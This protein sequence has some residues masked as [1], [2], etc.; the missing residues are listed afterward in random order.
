[1]GNVLLQVVQGNISI[2][3]VTLCCFS[4]AL[5]E[6]SSEQTLQDNFFIFPLDVDVDVV[7]AVV[8]V[9]VDGEEL[10]EVDE[11]EE[12][13]GIVSGAAVAVSI[14]AASSEGISGCCKFVNVGKNGNRGET[15]SP[16]ELR[17]LCCNIIWL[18]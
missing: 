7:A 9:D 14:G 1:M 6:N 2:S 4:N 15:M 5:D 10:E 11:E 8:D 13:D 17:Y 16:V 3:C 12:E 18:S